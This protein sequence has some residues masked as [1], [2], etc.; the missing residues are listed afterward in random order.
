[1]VRIIFKGGLVDWWI[2]GMDICFALLKNVE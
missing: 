1:V 2:H